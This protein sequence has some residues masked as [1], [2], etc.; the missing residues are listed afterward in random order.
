[1]RDLRLFGLRG[2]RGDNAPTVKHLTGVGVD[3]HPTMGLRN[4]KRQRRFAAGSRPGD[5]NRPVQSDFPH[6]RKHFM[7]FPRFP[8]IGRARRIVFRGN[9]RQFA[10]N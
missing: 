5:Q 1:M 8:A 9:F 4:L 3:D 10:Q 7:D 2:A 6:P